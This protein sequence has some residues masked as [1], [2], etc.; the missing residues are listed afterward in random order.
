[1]ATA[2]GEVD[3]GLGED[4]A[5]VH[6]CG[7]SMI[8]WAASPTG[9]FVGAGY[10]GD[11]SCY[12][13]PP[14]P[15]LG[16]LEASFTFAVSKQ[17]LLLVDESGKVVARG[18]REQPP[19][20]NEPFALTPRLRARLAD[21]KQLPQGVRPITAKQLQRRWVPKGAYAGNGRAFVAFADDRTWTG[22]D[23]CNGAGGRY[24]L[25]DFGEVLT[26]SGPTTLIG[27]ENSPAPVW[28]TQARRLGLVNG[29]LPLYDAEAALIGRLYQG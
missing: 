17:R 29:T 13:R 2:A 24:S 20:D 16:W 27:C 10:G 22:S 11:G 26:T 25:G 23:G 18:V 6:P 12:E 3:L 28:V 14:R 5:V 8:G 1:V 19:R 21:A 15:D 7:K 9:L 4:A